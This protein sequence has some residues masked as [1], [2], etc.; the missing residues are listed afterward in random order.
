MS[1][2]EFYPYPTDAGSLSLRCE[3]DHAHAVTEGGRV[4]LQG[5]SDGDTATATLIVSLGDDTLD[6]VLPEIERAAPPVAVLVIAQST[7]SRIRRAVTLT[8]LD[9]ATWTEELPLPKSHLY[10]RVVLEPVLIRTGPGSDPRYAQHAGARLAWGPEAQVEIDDAAIPEGGYIEIKWDDFKHSVNPVRKR[11]PDL[12]YA[13]DTEKDPP[14]L[15]LNSGIDQLKGVM[16]AKGPRGRNIRIRDAMNDVVVTQVWTS[17]VSVVMGRLAD[18]MSEEQEAE[19]ALEGLNDWESRVVHHWAPLLFPQAGT[20][21]EAI[22]DFA[23]Y[24]HDADLR[25]ALQERLG[26]AAQRQARTAYAFRGLVRL[27]DNEGV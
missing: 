13:L 17:L 12:V 25:P 23:D 8:K 14:M 27:R 24:S 7:E 15:W 20:R 1:H 16:H 21:A 19:A 18:E 26:M 6:R 11:N 10:G 3:V 2:V 5:L 22:T 4:L 9:G